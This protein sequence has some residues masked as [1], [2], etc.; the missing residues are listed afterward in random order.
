MRNLAPTPAIGEGASAELTAR[1]GSV[2]IPLSPQP[3]VKHHSIKIYL[4][5]FQPSPTFNFQ[6]FHFSMLRPHGWQLR[7]CDL[8]LRIYLPIWKEKHERLL[9]INSGFLIFELFAPVEATYIIVFQ[10][11]NLRRLLMQMLVRVE[12][13]PT[14]GDK[15]W[16]SSVI[17]QNQL[18][19][20]KFKPQRG[21]ILV[22]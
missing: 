21:E 16:S 22:E 11:T 14:E 9:V 1:G 10:K 6:N 15:A 2:A 7:I 13:C 19:S 18:W 12:H 5:S 17:H 4:C 8:Q 3:T 20:T